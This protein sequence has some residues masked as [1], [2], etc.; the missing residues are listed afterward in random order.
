MT[1]S[2]FLFSINLTDPLRGSAHSPL[3]VK[4]RIEGQEIFIDPLTGPVFSDYTKRLNKI[5]FTEDVFQ[6]TQAEK[7]KIVLIC[8]W[9]YNEWVVRNWDHEQ[10]HNVVPVFYID[11]KA[12]EKYISDGYEIFY[13][14]EQNLYNDQYSRMLFTDSLS[15][16]YM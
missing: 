4:F 10:N 6:K 1:M 5:A 13:L 8:G 15:K 16:P 9:W 3:S 2:S 7:R 11:Q 14:P 12:M